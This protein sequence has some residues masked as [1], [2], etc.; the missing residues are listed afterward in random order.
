MGSALKK[1]P[2]R[3]KAGCCVKS[4]VDFYWTNLTIVRLVSHPAHIYT[5]IY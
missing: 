2:E 5:S 4:D 3:K 1:K